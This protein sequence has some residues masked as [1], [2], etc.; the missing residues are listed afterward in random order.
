MRN[1]S[2]SLWMLVAVA[3]CA[4]VARGPGASP[5]APSCSDQQ[6]ATRW[7]SYL[8][9]EFTNPE[10]A[11]AAFRVRLG[12]QRVDSTAVIQAVTDPG[13]CADV[14]AV[15]G[16]ELSRLSFPF[17][18]AIVR[19]GPYYA[20][21]VVDATPPNG[22]VYDART[23]VWILDASTLRVLHDNILM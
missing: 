5:A 6:E 21:A 16:P 11:H 2:K 12:L 23:R 19:V 18:L 17:R 10:S 13:I 22:I 15:A 14:F 9:P 20:V 7:M 3:G 8:T 1:R 4:F